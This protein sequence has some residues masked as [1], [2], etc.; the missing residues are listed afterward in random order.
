MKT[1]D[2]LWCMVLFIPLALAGCKDAAS[3]RAKPPATDKERVSD[4]SADKQGQGE[5]AEI[6]ANL[7]K[8]GPEDRKLAEEQKFC[9][10]Q[11]DNRLGAMDVPIKVMVKD[12][13][14][15]VCCKGCVRRALNNPDQTLTR[16]EELKAKAAGSPKR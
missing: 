1:T 9:V 15:F 11:K 8:L 2:W 6:R 12:R 7:A 14:V 5:D 10:I 4:K 16:V 3:D 13:P